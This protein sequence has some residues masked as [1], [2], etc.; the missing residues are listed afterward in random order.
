M[1]EQS[2]KAQPRD[3]RAS[4]VNIAEK[5]KLPIISYKHTKLF[6]DYIRK[7]HQILKRFRKMNINYKLINGMLGH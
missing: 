6:N 4:L 1:Q 3:R 2:I 7:N 5:L